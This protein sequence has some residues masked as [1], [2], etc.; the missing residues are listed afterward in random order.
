MTAAINCT[1]GTVTA[2]TTCPNGTVIA[3]IS[4]TGGTVKEPAYDGQPAPG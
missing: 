4:R 1:G 3:A 2:T